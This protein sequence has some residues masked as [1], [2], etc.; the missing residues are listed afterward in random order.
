MTPALAGGLASILYL[1]AAGRFAVGLARTERPDTAYKYWNLLLG[2]GAL[3][4]HAL[5]LYQFIHTPAGLDLGFFHSLSLIA[6][7]IALFIVI[8]ALRSPLE[9]LTIILFPIAAISLLL[10]VFLPGSR[11]LPDATAGLQAHILLSISA[12]SLLGVAAVQA[13]VLAVQERQ[14]RHKHPGTIMRALPPLQ[15]MENLLFQLITIGFFLLSLSIATGF[16][17]LHDPFAQHLVHKTVLSLLAWIIFAILLWGRWAR[18][19]RGRVAIRWTL[20]GFGCLMLAYFGS[21]MA[22]ELILDRV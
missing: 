14:L 5:V 13:L 6:W 1:V 2:G 18:G 10:Q 20:G 21:K 22:L 8:G 16:M 15:V 19:W 7:L 11:I 12:Y 9:N 3:L 4:I 17:F